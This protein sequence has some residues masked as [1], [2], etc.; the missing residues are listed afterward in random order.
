MKV[1]SYPVAYSRAIPSRL[2]ASC[3]A[4]S[5]VTFGSRD[6]SSAGRGRARPV[7]R[8][9]SHAYV[10]RRDSSHVVAFSTSRTALADRGR[11]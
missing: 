3:I 10:F 4:S 6:T 7:P 1:V 5:S 11:R 2:T 8:D 9:G